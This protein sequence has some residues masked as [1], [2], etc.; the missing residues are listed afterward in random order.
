MN[1]IHD[2]IT[3]TAAEHFGLGYL[4]PYQRLVISN[5]LEAAGVP[6]FAPEPL[7]NP[8]TGE[9]EMRD[10]APH[11]IVILP[12]GAGKSLCFILPA[13]MLAGP[14]LVVFPLLSLIADQ[15]RRLVKAG[16]KPGILR[17]GQ[18]KAEREAVFE[19]ARRG[20][21]RMILTN[22][23]TALSPPVLEKLAGLDIRHLVIDEAHTVSEWGESFRP[24]YLEVGRLAVEA[25]I[26][27]VT[28]FTATASP[29]ILE[30]VRDIIFPHTSPNIIAANPDRPN[31]S[32]RVIPVIS[33]THEL[34]A[35][36]T[37]TSTTAVERPVIVFCG[38]RRQTELL[39]A[40][41][42]ERL[43]EEQIFFYHAG[44]S[45]QEKK[46]VEEWFFTSPY[47]IL[48]ATCAYGMGVDKSNV[49]T[50]IHHYVPPSV[51][52]YLQESGRA[53]RD[54]KQA[55]AVLLFSPNDALKALYGRADASGERYR[56]LA[57]MAVKHDV[58]RRAYLLS[59][60]GAPETACSGCDVCAGNVKKIPAELWKIIDFFRCSPGVYT[61]TEAVR[62][63]KGMNTANI[64]GPPRFLTPGYGIL[65]GWHDEDIEEAISELLAAGLVKRGKWGNSKQRL[66]PGAWKKNPFS[67][68]RSFEE[69]AVI[70]PGKK[71]GIQY[72]D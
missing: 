2:P 41:L 61:L 39:A 65:E 30:E 34:T 52:A 28:A 15:A 58:C 59:L 21:I 4:F 67:M 22:P 32:Y 19:G 37:T 17:G 66:K 54:M 8:V 3:E 56:A 23:E 71:R 69:E 43:R 11:Q 16:M 12:T 57:G 1:N 13:L 60:M 55:E 38:S 48:V 63:L 49:R 62:I 6:G 14:T 40:T 50:V 45:K 31:I 36:L 7:V 25:G 24:V 20:E 68:S 9:T 72:K 42:R 10:T 29:L 47:G 70:R 26:P 18:P 46:T 27:M 33:K 44:L 53:G 5:I 51:E 64:L 35:L